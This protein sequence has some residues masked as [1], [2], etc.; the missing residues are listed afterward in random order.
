MPSA[1]LTS[2]YRHGFA[3]T[4]DTDRSRIN[5]SPQVQPEADFHT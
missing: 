1:L 3:L 4:S 5:F 2:A